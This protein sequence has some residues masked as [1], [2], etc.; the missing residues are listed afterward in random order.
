MGRHLLHLGMSPLLTMPYKRGVY[1]P[2]ETM[3]L[4]APH[5][6]P[7]LRNL[8]ALADFSGVALSI[9]EGDNVSP[10]KAHN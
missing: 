9:L 3:G 10:S 4:A 7:I 5:S 6:S 1:L 2:L 8:P